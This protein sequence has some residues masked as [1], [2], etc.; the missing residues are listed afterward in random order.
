[1]EIE[2]L[3]AMSE[4]ELSAQ[5]KTLRKELFNLRFQKVV[6]HMENPSR[7]KQLRRE[8]ARILTCVS[9]LKS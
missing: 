2:K 5:E 9:A 4:V 3:R 6:G 7:I 8:I 1:M